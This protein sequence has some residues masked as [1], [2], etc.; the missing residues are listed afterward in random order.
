MGDLFAAMSHWGGPAAVFLQVV[1]IDLTMAG[2]NAVAVGLAANGLPRSQRHRAIVLGLGAAVV[3]LIGFALIAV[4]LLKIIG[5]LLAGG[6]LLLW[7]CWR[8]WRDLRAQDLARAD[9]GDAEAAIAPKSMGR[10][11]FEILAAD[12]S[13]SLDNVLGVA[14]AA[15]DHPQVLVFGLLLS[16]TATGLA[17]SAIARLLHRA[18]WLGYIGLAI[19]MFVAGHM[20]WDGA[21]QIRARV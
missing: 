12:L 2:D 7:V 3:M 6:L 16:I 13:M 10:A 4:Q 5:L 17:A 21:M 19:V 8:M 14:G 15:R 9:G 20:I 1:I 18:P 11:L